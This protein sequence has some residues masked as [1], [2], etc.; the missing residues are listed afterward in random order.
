M[1]ADPGASHAK[2]GRPSPATLDL[3]AETYAVLRAELRDATAELRP[4][5]PTA[6][7]VFGEPVAARP[8]LSDR[9]RLVDLIGKLL[10]LLGSEVVAAPAAEDAPAKRPR[11]RRPDY[12]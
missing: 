10:G 5:A 7:P 3:L 4:P 2:R 11:L 8:A 9:V 6:P 1:T 12:G